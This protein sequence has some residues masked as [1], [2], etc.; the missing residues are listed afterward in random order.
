MKESPINILVVKITGTLVLNGSGDGRIR[1][2]EKRLSEFEIILD[3]QEFSP[4]TVFYLPNGYLCINTSVGDEQITT[5][6]Y[7]L[8]DWNIEHITKNVPIMKKEN[9]I[10]NFYT[11]FLNEKNKIDYNFLFEPNGKL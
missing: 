9:F 11:S 8:K 10:E 2:F 4:D 3:N 1:N 6:I 5:D 7:I